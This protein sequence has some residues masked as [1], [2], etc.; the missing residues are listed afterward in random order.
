MADLTGKTL[1]KYRL[2][3]RLGRGGMAEVYRAYQTGLE[4][5]VA[6]KVMHSHLAED[7]DFI[8]RFQR[9]AKA[10]AA[11]HH[12]NIVQVYD[13]DVEDD[14][15]YMVMEYIGG[16]SLKARLQSYYKDNKRMSLDEIVHIMCSL[17]DALGYAHKLGHVHRDIKPA[18][19]MFDGERLVL[20]DFGIATIIGGPRYTATGAMIGTPAYM[21][22]E[23][24]EGRIEGQTGD[25]YS[26]GVI[27]YEMVTGRIPFDA[28]T[29]LAIVLKHINEPLPLPSQVAPGVSASLEKII[30][31]ALAKQPEERYQTAE[32]MANALTAATQKEI[33]EAKSM[34]EGFLP[35]GKSTVE[36]GTSTLDMG[37][38]DTADGKKISATTGSKETARKKT[39]SPMAI[40]G[41]V[42]ATIIILGGLTIFGALYVFPRITGDINKNPTQK[43]GI[44]PT[45]VAYYVDMES[46][47]EALR[48]GQRE[49][50]EDPISAQE[51]YANAR[52]YKLRGDTTNALLAYEGYFE[53]GLEYIDP[54]EE[55]TA[56][57]KATEGVMRTQEKIRGM[58]NAEADNVSLELIL[59]ELEE[60]PETR[61]AKLD[62][63]SR[64]FPQYGPAFFSLGKI[65]GSQLYQG[66]TND[67]YEK[68][69]ASYKTLFSLEQNLQYSRFYIDKEQAQKNLEEAQKE[70]DLFAQSGKYLSKTDVMITNLST[71]TLFVITLMEANV[72]NIFYS[73]DDPKPTRS[74]GKSAGT[75]FVNPSIGPVE[76]AI[77]EHVF[78]FKY[79]DQNDVES[80]VFEKPF[81]VDAITVNFMQ[82]PP[83]LTTN[84]S[85]GSFVLSIV[86][87]EEGHSYVYR[88]SIDSEALDLETT[89]I[90]VASVEVKQLL[91][92]KHSMH[93]Q[94]TDDKGDKTPVVKYEFEV[95]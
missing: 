55:Y 64:R 86:L 63:L 95:K 59:A 91:I 92:G 72:K 87:P 26:L 44:S 37:V 42:I 5:D 46:V 89:S 23:Q 6:I 27:L 21:P 41:I 52:V 54:Y 33:A 40:T 11:M 76:I 94:A 16:E 79:I 80:K 22:P 15:Y 74:T 93:V 48:A 2:T 29:P 68:F 81:T 66:M 65:Y 82:N 85:S 19:V 84:V 53:F 78:Y 70:I 43:Q 38:K 49:I 20:T 57:L 17:C 8:K 61:I 88:Y 30:L 1:G 77:G 45:D 14:I 31:K 18:N 25:I 24:G 56:L 51:W 67:L 13:F 9:E 75:D 39:R 3:E 90:E 4:R 7:E 83:D 58:H 36:K 62:D 35:P 12:P 69:K 32:A 60:S 34:D 10:V 28:D 50:I 73:V 71:G 47:L